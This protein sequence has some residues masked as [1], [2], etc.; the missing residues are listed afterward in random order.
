VS[1]D[2]CERMEVGETVDLIDRL[3]K[4]ACTN[5]EEELYEVYARIGAARTGNEYFMKK[6]PAVLKKCAH[7]KYRDVF[8]FWI[9]KVKGI[10]SWS[11]DLFGVIRKQ[12]EEL[13]VL[14]EKRFTL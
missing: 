5:K 6:I 8:Q 11:P 7:K 4:S 2:V 1:A 14:A 9:E 3:E 12:I 10:E 13:E